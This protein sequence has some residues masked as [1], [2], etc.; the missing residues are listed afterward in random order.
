MPLAGLGAQKGDRMFSARKFCS[1]IAIGL[2]SVSITN[3]SSQKEIKSRISGRW[4]PNPE[5]QA[6]EF[7]DTLQNQMSVLQ[8][9]SDTA[10]VGA[11]DSNKHYWPAN[12]N[13]WM[14]VVQ[15]GFNVGK[16][17]CEIYM[18]NLFRMAR[19][20]QRNDGIFNAA[21]LASIA[22]LTATRAVKS[23]SIV[24]ASFGMLTSL[25]DSVYDSYLFTQAPGLIALKV[26]GLQ[27]TY[28]TS[29]ESSPNLITSPEIAYAAIQ[30]YYR[31]CLPHEIEGVLLQKIA[32]SQPTIT[33]PTT[34]PKKPAAAVPAPK[35]KAATSVT[36]TPHLQ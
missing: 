6:M 11:L 2:V 14:R 26:K 17:D 27:D 33:P 12:P 21:G 25:N 23:V 34:P 9:I 16:V 4:G 31:I 5:I 29:I 28:Q 24:G 18:D 30:N 7:N 20:R 3:C 32:D 15:A 35:P 10:G 36:Q 13:D 22:I 19:E 8:Y 1:V